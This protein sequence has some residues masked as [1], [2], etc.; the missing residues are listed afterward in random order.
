LA[1][2]NE[3]SHKDTAQ[4]ITNIVVEDQKIP[5]NDRALILDELEKMK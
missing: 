2:S 1:D 4:I 5:W 3:L